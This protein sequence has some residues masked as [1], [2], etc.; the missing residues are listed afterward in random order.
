MIGIVV[1][2]FENTK[3]YHLR[4]IVGPLFLAKVGTGS[5]SAYTV[6][7][8]TDD[9]RRTLSAENIHER[10]DSHSSATRT[11]NGAESLLGKDRTVK[12]HRRVETYVTIAAVA[13]AFFAE[14]TQ[15]HTPTAYTA[16]G[17]GLHTRQ[18]FHI[19][20]RATRL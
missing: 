9:I 10:E 2:N 4:Y 6:E 11:H 1:G 16:L 13:A 7:P 19:H 12:P 18:F 20:S 5:E 3:L 15:Q 14:I 8:C 17:V